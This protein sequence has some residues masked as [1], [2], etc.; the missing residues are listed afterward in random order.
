MKIRI[1]SKPN[2]STKSDVNDAEILW[3]DTKNPFSPVEI[4]CPIDGK[5]LQLFRKDWDHF[6][7]RLIASNPTKQEFRDKLQKKSQSLEQII[8]GNRSLPWKNSNFK[9]E[10]FLQTDP[11]FTSFP[12]EIF[13]TNEIFFFEY[14]LFY[15]GIRST[16]R[17]SEISK[18]NAFLLIENPVLK[19]LETS[20]KREGKLISEIFEDQQKIPFKRIKAD[21]WKLTKFW[22]EI[23]DSAYLHY[24]GHT[25]KEGI[26]IQKDDVILGEEIGRAKLSNL[27]VVFLNSCH[28]AY[29]GWETSG[30]A[31]QFL[32][33]GAQYVLGFLTPVETEVAEQIGKEFWTFYLKSKNPRASYLKVK[34]NLQNADSKRLASSLSFVCFSPEQKKSKSNLIFAFVL[35]LLLLFCLITISYF[36]KSE[37]KSSD[38]FIPTDS[39]LPSVNSKEQNGQTRQSILTKISEIKDPI[40]RSKAKSFWVEDHPFLTKEERRNILEEILNSDG[41]EEVKF[42]QFK[43]NTGIE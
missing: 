7:N 6:L 16:S 8:F 25:E 19:E 24:A 5:S 9:S 26:P 2:R 36:R 35:S 41:N 3:E 37:I 28:S 27:K 38:Q 22:E 21:Q 20:V 12:W 10:I 14:K 40:F 32:K 42:Y 15:R 11:E 4:I 34:E 13:T 39:I 33:A 43:R 29:E 23:T 17:V 30:L 1:I 18:G 31:S